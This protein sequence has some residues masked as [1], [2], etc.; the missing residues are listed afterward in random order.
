MNVRPLPSP[1]RSASRAGFTIIE[2]LV[3]MVGMMIVGGI[4]LEVYVETQRA[5]QKM[6]RRQAGVDFAV[7]F[8]DQAAELLRNAVTPANLDVEVRPVFTADRFSIPA[9]GDPASNGLFLVTVRPAEDAAGGRPYEIVREVVAGAGEAAGGSQTVNA[10]GPALS[11]AEAK[12]SFRYATEAKPGAVN[13][14]NRLEAGQWPLLV[15]IAV[16]VTPPAEG[17]QPVRMRTAVIPGRLGP[18]APVAPTPT[19]TPIPG[20]ALQ[21]G[22]AVQAPAGA[23][24]PTAA[25]E[26]AAAVT[27]APPVAVPAAPPTETQP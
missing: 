1:P 24:A 4:V 21:A 25:A 5:A 16:E 19:P 9:Y 7:A 8:T 6:V 10:F 15:E 22:Q 18:L 13:Y 14:V 11:E 20:A 27:I 23:Q 3:A 12:V 26:P 17:E 2:V